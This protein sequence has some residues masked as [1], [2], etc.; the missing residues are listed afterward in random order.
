MKRV[1]LELQTGVDRGARMVLTPGQSVTVG[2][3]P[4]ADFPLPADDMLSRNHLTVHCT[5][6]ECIVEDLKSANGTFVNGQ[7]ITKQ[8][9]KQGDELAAGRSRFEAQ[10]EGPWDEET[11]SGSG[12]GPS[13][14]ESPKEAM[15]QQSPA[16]AAAGVA[17]A[18]AAAGTE[19][20][21]GLS[22]NKRV[23]LE[24]T[25]GYE[26]GGRVA[27]YPRRILEV[28]R[29]D[30]VGFPIVSDSVLSGKHFAIACD[31]NSAYLFD[32]DSAN[33][34]FLNG[35]RVKSSALREDDEIAAGR[36]KFKLTFVGGWV[37]PQD[38]SVPAHIEALFSK[39]GKEEAQAV[40]YDEL[41]C[42]S[43]LYAYQASKSEKPVRDL[44]IHLA[45]NYPLYFIVDPVKLL[46]DEPEA[47]E[48]AE[49]AETEEEEA[50]PAATAPG[51]EKPG[52]VAGIE[53]GTVKASKLMPWFPDDAKPPNPGPLLLHNEELPN[54]L[55]TFDKLWGEDAM[56]AC[57]TSDDKPTLLVHLRKQINPQ[58][59]KVQGIYSP[60]VLEQILTLFKP[61]KVKPI[62][63][64]IKAI[65]IESAEEPQVWKLFSPEPL[66]KVLEKMGME[67][68][69]PPEEQG[70]ETKDDKQAPAKK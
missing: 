28:G 70:E 32:L 1:V 49:V 29:H 6:E 43:K 5:E 58:P 53:P 10:F 2:R 25:T 60:M 11:L 66:D 31:D 44:L 19:T 42:D 18:G 30:N 21:L 24:V 17:V 13:A 36:S 47:A 63:E 45:G 52:S 68:R 16:T 9:L 22:P 4:G 8:P 34:T 38:R 50:P 39:E 23:F 48:E 40:L 33:G 51:D 46:G 12:S 14:E 3:S 67:R 54:C 64:H 7:R 41:E 59:G 56:I 57:F 27:I 20:T 37:S 61:N 69:P 26:E 62:V 15:S 35:K 55:D 65:V